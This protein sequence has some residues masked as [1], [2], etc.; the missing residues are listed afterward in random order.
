MKFSRSLIIRVLLFAV[1]CVII[2][3]LLPTKAQIYL[4]G[5]AMQKGIDTF[6]FYAPISDSIF[7]D[8]TGG[9]IPKSIEGFD[10][11]T[12]KELGS[13]INVNYDET[14]ELIKKPFGSVWIIHALG[15]TIINLVKQLSE[16]AVNGKI[17][18]LLYT[19]ILSFL[20]ILFMFVL[21]IQMFS[22]KLVA[23]KKEELLNFQ[24]K[25]AWVSILLAGLNI[26]LL[27]TLLAIITFIIVSSIPSSIQLITNPPVVNFGQI[28]FGISFYFT[29]FVYL[30]CLVF[31]IFL[32][33]F[34]FRT[35]HS[36]QRR[37]YS[38]ILIIPIIALGYNLWSSTKFVKGVN[39][40]IEQQNISSNRQMVIQ[41][42]CK[43]AYSTRQWYCINYKESSLKLEELTFS[44]DA[45][46]SENENGKYN[47]EIEG[48]LL[49]ITG[50]G[51][52]EIE[53]GTYPLS[54]TTYNAKTDSIRTRLI[55]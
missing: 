14:I 38:V 15:L 6:N 4:E 54:I 20:G 47:F 22:K 26:I 43:I 28:D 42:C 16:T 48:D 25:P 37:I 32:I 27:A 35:H 11:D 9:N 10:F 46:L 52:Y 31:S 7:N 24:I 40:I 36:V 5:K 13:D 21:Y 18:Y 45:F 34:F 17:S 50:E 53:N 41:D 3:G 23:F 51:K 39:K 12:L 55:Q 29:A 44:D 8:F 30:F 33:V 2:V 19:T 49:T 1:I